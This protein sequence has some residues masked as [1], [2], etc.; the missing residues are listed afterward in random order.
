MPTGCVLVLFLYQATALLFVEAFLFSFQIY[1]K[2]VVVAVSVTGP[3][4]L[5][6][7]FKVDETPN[8]V[9]TVAIAVVAL[10]SLTTVP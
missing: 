2:T 10:T 4:Q 8:S 6:K 5:K 9:H 7:H 3:R 1:E